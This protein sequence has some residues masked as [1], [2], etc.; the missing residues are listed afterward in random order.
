MSNKAF[1]IVPLI[2]N[3]LGFGIPAIAGAIERAKARKEN[4]A[5]AEVEAAATAAGANAAKSIGSVMAASGASV[6]VADQMGLGAELIHQMTQVPVELLPDHAP[7][8][9]QYA[10]FGITV[11]GMVLRFVANKYPKPEVKP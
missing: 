1:P 3:V 4:K 2:S 10:Y 8:W 6:G 11:I 5:L 9:V 7:D